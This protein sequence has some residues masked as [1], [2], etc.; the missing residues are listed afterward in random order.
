MSRLDMHDKFEL[1]LTQDDMY[2]AFAFSVVVSLVRMKVI[3]GQRGD[4]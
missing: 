4:L 1:D 3:R 2:P